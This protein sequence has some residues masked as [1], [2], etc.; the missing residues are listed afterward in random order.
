[1]TSEYAGLDEIQG[2]SFGET[3]PNGEIVMVNFHIRA[4]ASFGGKEGTRANVMIPF[5]FLTALIEGLPGLIK[6]M[7]DE[8][9]AC[10]VLPPPA[11][12]LPE[13][14]AG[15]QWNPEL[16]GPYLCTYFNTRDIAH[17][18][19][20]VVLTIGIAK[21]G[22]HASASESPTAD[23]LMG[24]SAVLALQEALPKVV[25]KLEQR[26]AAKRPRLH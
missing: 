4:N 9:A 26:A 19:G 6:A 24:W 5:E 18:L 12:R 2:V 15:P 17:E 11:V 25:R 8:G 22:V 21:P 23:Y 3:D 10:N 7:R 16:A 14:N 20:A 1:M 13:W